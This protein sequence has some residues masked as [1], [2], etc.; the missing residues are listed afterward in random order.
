MMTAMSTHP[1]AT[2]TP[3]LPRPLHPTPSTQHTPVPTPTPPMPLPVSV[4]RSG[5]TMAQPVGTRNDASPTHRPSLQPLSPPMLTQDS[6]SDSGSLLKCSSSQPYSPNKPS[7]E[8]LLPPQSFNH[9]AEHSDS[10]SRTMLGRSCPPGTPAQQ[11]LNISPTAAGRLPVRLG[12]SD[13]RLHCYMR[14]APQSKAICAVVPSQP[15]QDRMTHDPAHA[16]QQQLLRHQHQQQQQEVEEEEEEEV[17]EMQEVQ[18]VEKQEQTKR[19]TQQHQTR[20]GQ[21]QEQKRQQDRQAQE[22]MPRISSLQHHVRSGLGIFDKDLLAK[23]KLEEAVTSVTGDHRHIPFAQGHVNPEADVRRSWSREHT[24]LI[25][26]HFS[27]GLQD[28]PHLSEDNLPGLGYD[29]ADDSFRVDSPPSNHSSRVTKHSLSPP[30]SLPSPS[31][32]LISLSPDLPGSVRDRTNFSDREGPIPYRTAPTH[33][34]QGSLSQRRDSSLHRAGPLFGPGTMPQPNLTPPPSA[35][36]AYELDSRTFSAQSVSPQPNRPRSL[37]KFSTKLHHSRIPFR[38]P[39]R[40]SSQELR[41][42]STEASATSDTF[43]KMDFYELYLK[44]PK[45]LRPQGGRIEERAQWARRHSTS[46]GLGFGQAS[47]GLVNTEGSLQG[48]MEDVRGTSAGG[49]YPTTSSKVKGKLKASSKGTGGSKA[50]TAA[51]PKKPSGVSRRQSMP[52]ILTA[53]RRVLRNEDVKP[54]MTTDQDRYSLTKD[55]G[56]MIQSLGVRSPEKAASRKPWSRS[57]STLPMSNSSISMLEMTSS[58]RATDEHDSGSDDVPS[59]NEEYDEDYENGHTALRHKK[60]HSMSKS[61]HPGLSGS[62]HSKKHSRKRSSITLQQDEHGHGGHGESSSKARKKMKKSVD[63]D[64]APATGFRH[65]GERV[66]QEPE[67]LVDIE[68]D[69]GPVWMLDSHPPPRVIW[70]GQPLSIVGKLGYERLHPYEEHIASTLRLSPAQYLSCKRILI[71]ASREYLANPDGKQFRKSDAQKLCRIDVNKTSRLW[72]VFAKIG[73]L[74]GI[75]EK[76]I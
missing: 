63:P 5:S 48:R 8:P 46:S 37:S 29:F 24:P 76:D 56:E 57:V 55:T 49:P 9:P 54:G 64:S 72:E 45:L 42:L 58:S 7:Q 22:H 59:G 36:P 71:M 14:G 53:T 41:T 39:D 2:L 20:Q 70:K 17:D 26:D 47:H 10:S 68:P 21:A 1:S 16:L 52:L 6:D 60:T 25:R 4:P 65:G 3:S 67:E 32:S 11:T 62:V 31:P 40:Q 33:L 34:K 51:V 75:T 27:S 74:A 13:P 43:F 50:N 73:W 69:I 12:L 28:R 66:V 38:S 30:T 18:E 61:E 19:Q 15:R 44:N 35:W 23:S